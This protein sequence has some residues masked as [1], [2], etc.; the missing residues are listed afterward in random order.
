M[1]E[2]LRIVADMLSGV[3]SDV[4]PVVIMYMVLKFLK[5]PLIAM[6]F[7]YVVI[8]VTGRMFNDEV[9]VNVVEK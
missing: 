3:T 5:A 9:T 8:R 1:V 2:E 6:I 7:G 4:V